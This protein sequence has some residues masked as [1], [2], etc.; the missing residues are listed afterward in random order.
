MEKIEDVLDSEIITKAAAEARRINAVTNEKLRFV[1]IV[2]LILKL[3]VLE[4]D[5]TSISK[6]DY[7]R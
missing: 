7:R 6:E 1:E 2:R 5:L 3:A 4:N